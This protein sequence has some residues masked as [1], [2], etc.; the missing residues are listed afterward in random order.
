VATLS[1]PPGNQRLEIHYTALSFTAPEK[2][3]FKY[4][5]EGFDT[6][7][8]DAGN[9]RVA[10]FQGLPPGQFKFHVIAAN[11][12]GDWNKLGASLAFT[13]LPYFWQTVW[14]QCLMALAF[15]GG[16]LGF[17]HWRVSQLRHQQALRDEFSRQ[18]IENQDTERKRV[19][20]ELHDSLGQNLLIV[21]N[22]A[23]MGLSSSQST[24]NT[25]EHL[26]EISRTASQ[27]IQEVRD[28]AYNLRP[29]QLDQFGLSE[30]IEAVISR[31]AAASGVRFEIKVDP[32]DNLFTPADE[33]HLFRIIQEAANNIVKHSGASTARVELRR[34]AQEIRLLIQDD[35]CGLKLPGNGLS[36]AAPTGSGLPGMAE[37]V[38]ILRGI[39]EVNSIPG[40][41]VEIH[42]T[43][44]V[45][46]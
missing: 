31:V 24:E 5:L 36:T 43:V 23:L 2:V 12:D 35:G 20:S 10:Y 29:Y 27:A 32:V 9:R 46:K 16:V 21:K 28:I 18:L 13:V 8:T 4:Q 40:K 25:A 7:W 19:A 38:R 41:G 34:Q 26:R 33:S 22:R 6:Q 42:I 14:F 1:V 17:Y 39:L 30:G 37:R 3:S 45:P 11:N 44:P 15:S